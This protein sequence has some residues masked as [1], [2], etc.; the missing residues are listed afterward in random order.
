[1]KI[2]QIRF[3]IFGQNN[4]YTSK[5]CQILKS[6][7]TATYLHMKGLF[8]VV[9]VKSFLKEIEIVLKLLSTF[10]TQLRNKDLW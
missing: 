10:V 6:S 1:M 8:S 4:K 3:K 2:C 5:F 9:Y 7:N